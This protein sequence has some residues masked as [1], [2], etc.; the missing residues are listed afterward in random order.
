MS[1]PLPDM[2]RALRTRE[3]EQ[4]LTPARVRFALA[5]WAFVA[6]RPRLYQPLMASAMAILGRLGHRRGRFKRLPLAGGWTRVRD[7]P[8]PEGQTFQNAWREARRAGHS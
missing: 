6:K 3:F 8:A 1:I 2:L 4:H 7:L 5:A